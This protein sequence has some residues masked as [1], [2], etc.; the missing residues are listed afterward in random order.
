MRPALSGSRHL[1]RVRAGPLHHPGGAMRG[2]LGMDTGPR[3]R[4]RTT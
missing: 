4:R 1:T 3:G 2:W